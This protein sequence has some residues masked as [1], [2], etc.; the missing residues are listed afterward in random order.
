MTKLNIGQLEN[1]GKSM[2]FRSA[3]A[4]APRPLDRVEFDDWII[5]CTAFPEA[6]DPG[7]SLLAASSRACGCD[8][9]I[10]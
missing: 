7:Q 8:E 5:D 4:S 10:A 6:T 9:G 3:S 2:G 1:A